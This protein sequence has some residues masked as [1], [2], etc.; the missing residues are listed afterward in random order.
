MTIRKTKEGKGKEYVREDG[1][2]KC[3]IEMNKDVQVLM[4]EGQDE[5]IFQDK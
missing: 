2:C 3:K 4:N 1:G 5:I